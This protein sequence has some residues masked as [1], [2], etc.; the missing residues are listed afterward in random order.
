M[1]SPANHQDTPLTSAL[2]VAG[3]SAML[4][5][6]LMLYGCGPEWARWDAAQAVVAYDQGDIEQAIYQLTTAVERSPRDPG[7]KLSLANKLIESDRFKEAETLCDQILDRFPDNDDAWVTKAHSQQKQGNFLQAL[8]T[9][10]ARAK[11][12]NW[13]IANNPG[14]LNERA[15]FRALAGV[16]LRA[17]REDIDLACQI[18]ISRTRLGQLPVGTGMQYRSLIASS[19][20]AMKVGMAD[21]AIERLSVLILR[22]RE[23]IYVAQTEL[24]MATVVVTTN[25]Y[26]PTSKQ[27]SQHD[28]L[29]ELIRI[30]E[31]MLGALLTVRALCYE[32]Q[33]KPDRC[34]T[35]RAEVNSM[36]MDSDV[37]AA[38][39]PDDSDCVWTIQTSSAF[40][41][42]RGYIIGLMPSGSGGQDT[43]EVNGRKIPVG[44]NFEDALR[45]LDQ[46]VF[47]F[48][49]FEK[50]LT[51]NVHNHA[52]EVLF[53]PVAE[54]KNADQ[55]KAVLL[56]HRMVVRKK[57]GDFDGA[58]EDAAAIRGLN[59]E[60]GPH[61]F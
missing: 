32:Q 40:L 47:A 45:D 2:T 55:H 61:L 46:S 9:F 18:V 50:S 52:S 31:Q 24:N 59:L 8:E 53:D 27:T 60:P 14:R 51:S 58:A 49:V 3:F 44:I 56:Y 21:V 36:A 57:A 28:R 20:I 11:Q 10:N 17:A 19:M 43:I 33:D 37:I 12:R 23:L 30:N 35:D 6:P 5:L 7:L 41:D 39:L 15:Y 22:L 4:L 26:P 1:T 16:Q 42:T 38:Q 48:E 34:D 54:L 25:N 29:R 13:L